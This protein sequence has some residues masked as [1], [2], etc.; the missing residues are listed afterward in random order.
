MSKW[1]KWKSFPDP[2]KN[3]LITAPFG[4][5]VYVLRNRKTKEL[6]LFGSGKNCAF[7]MSSLLPKELGSGTRNN[8]EKRDYVLNNISQIEYCCLPCE[9]INIAREEEKSLKNNK[10]RTYL[11]PT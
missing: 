6:V 11:F 10:S 2:R 1:T 9:N 4:P 3:E 5:G 8:L 7:R